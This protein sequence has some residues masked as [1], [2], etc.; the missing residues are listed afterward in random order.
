MH[1]A[2][3]QDTDHH[4]WLVVEKDLFTDYVWITGEALLPKSVADERHRSSSRFVVFGR[5]VAA[6]QWR[7]AHHLQVIGSDDAT[8]EVLRFVGAGDV[9][10][11]AAKRRH[12]F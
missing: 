1:K 11:V 4:V 12:H 10:R 2:F 6:Q 9:Y 8:I 3:G 7:C 5:E